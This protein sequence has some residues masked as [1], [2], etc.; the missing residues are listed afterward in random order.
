MNVGSAGCVTN[1]SHS[2]QS[3]LSI[4]SVG[5]MS[6][7]RRSVV[8]MTKSSPFSKQIF[9]HIEDNGGLVLDEFDEPLLIAHHRSEGVP[10][11]ELVAIYELKEIRRM[12]M[13]ANLVEP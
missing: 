11:G 13:T 8:T 1:Q 7:A 10:D 5:G 12:Q 6:G 4:L 3:P 9:V 2:S